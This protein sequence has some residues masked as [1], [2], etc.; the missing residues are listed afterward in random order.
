[1]VWGSPSCFDVNHDVLS[2]NGICDGA[3]VE[4]R[5]MG[6]EHVPMPSLLHIGVWEKK[7]VNGGYPDPS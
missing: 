3:E 7:I 2:Q 4:Q 1:M 6:L 5:E